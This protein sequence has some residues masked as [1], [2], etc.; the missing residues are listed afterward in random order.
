MA[1]R[2]AAS[3]RAPQPLLR[4]SVRTLH[5]S[6]FA[7]V[8][9]TGIVSAGLRDHGVPALSTALMWLTAACY[10]FLVVLLGW[11]LLA[12]AGEVRRD[13]SDPQRGF[14]FFTFVAGTEVLGTRLALAGHHGAATGLLVLGGVSWLVLGYLIPST[15]I[16][17][18]AIRPIVAGA[19]GTWFIWA[20][21]TQSVAV[22][23]A[24]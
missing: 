14:G 22:L 16:L 12:F 19:N 17:G 13:G 10:L 8:M 15:A 5:P 24:T 7:L 1:P 23:T 9:A 20:V 6:Y 11:R 2:E 4:E 3:D 21:G 18:G